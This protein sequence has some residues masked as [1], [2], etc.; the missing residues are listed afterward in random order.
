VDDSDPAKAIFKT[1]HS[2]IPSDVE[3]SRQL[4]YQKAAQRIA[5]ELVRL[6]SKKRCYK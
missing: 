5:E 4:Q 6:N 3:E 2:Q 1:I